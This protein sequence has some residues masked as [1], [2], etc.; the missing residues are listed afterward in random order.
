MIGLIPIA[1]ILGLWDVTPVVRVIEEN[2]MP[3]IQGDIVDDRYRVDDLLAY[4]GMSAVYRAYDTNLQVE[5]A[6]KENYFHTPQAIEQ[7]K[8]EAR[9]LAKLRHVGLPRVLQ[10]F[11]H[12]GQQYLV[13]EFMEG[14]NLWE[15]VKQRGKPF[16]ES[17]TLDRMDK[18][19]EAA[20]Y[21]HSQSPPI[22]HRDDIINRDDFW[23]AVNNCV[24]SGLL[25]GVIAP[26]PMGMEPVAGGYG[27]WG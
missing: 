27:T 6:I 15:M 23:R 16:T 9:V 24:V 2:E 11:I 4:G 20:Q 25:P 13:M 1:A 8:R 14:A 18:V 19:C 5:V 7:F 12:E 26:Q 10:H 17:Q 21:L 22:I 3:L